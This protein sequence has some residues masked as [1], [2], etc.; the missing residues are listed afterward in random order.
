MVCM[1][2]LDRTHVYL[3]A[4][5]ARNACSILPSSALVHFECLMRQL[6]DRFL[7]TATCHLAIAI[8]IATYYN[9]LFYRTKY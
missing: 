5:L 8:L 3:E 7:V 4:C 1:R 9:Y 2:I 6:S